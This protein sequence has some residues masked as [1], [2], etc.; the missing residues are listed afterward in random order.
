MEISHI[1]EVW[2]PMLSFLELEWGRSLQNSIKIFSM[3]INDENMELE[4]V[5]LM[6]P[7]IVETI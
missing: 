7:S 2:L 4:S 3:M 1:N 5:S 6:D